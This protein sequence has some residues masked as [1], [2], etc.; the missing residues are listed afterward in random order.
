MANKEREAILQNARIALKERFVGIDNVIDTLIDKIH[1]WYCRPQ[2]L[3]RPTIISIYGLT[4]VGK[5]EMIHYLVKL[6]GMEQTFCTL[7]IGSHETSYSMRGYLRSDGI[8]YDTHGIFFIDEIQ[9]VES[10]ST[11]HGSLLNGSLFHGFWSLLSNGRLEN[12][13]DKLA[14]IQSLMNQLRVRTREV[15][16]VRQSIFERRTSDDPA[17][18]EKVYNEFS[19]YIE[20][21]MNSACMYGNMITDYI[22]DCDIQGLWRYKSMYQSQMTCAQDWDYVQGTVG[23]HAQILALA[24][25]LNDFIVMEFLKYKYNQYQQQSATL[26]DDDFIYKKLLI[27]VAGNLDDIFIPT[28]KPE[29]E[30]TCDDVVKHVSKITPNDVRKALF[31]IFRPE[32]VSRFGTNYIIMP[33]LTEDDYLKIIEKEINK[34]LCIVTEQYDIDLSKVFTPS[35][36]FAK[37]K[38]RGFFPSQGVRPILSSVNSIITEMLPDILLQHESGA[39]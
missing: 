35:V 24:N 32:Q 23:R 6:L 16:R 13:G 22:E 14:N 1:I 20:G 29:Y 21:Q 7:D 39:S 18:M 2:Y 9:R 26:S 25:S 27:L 38:E 8:K 33:A 28:G 31:K 11:V 3:F 34:W 12:V 37:L 10:V 5:T 30:L 19:K 36:I 17:E 15:E 4:G